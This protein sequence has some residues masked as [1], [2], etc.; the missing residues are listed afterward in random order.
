MRQLHPIHDAHLIGNY[1]D[2]HWVLDW[3]LGVRSEE[4]GVRSEE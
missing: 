3:E 1:S 2:S 4:L